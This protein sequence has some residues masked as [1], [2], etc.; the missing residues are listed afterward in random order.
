VGVVHVA[1]GFLVVGRALNS[2]LAMRLS[3][4]PIIGP[5][6]DS[7]R[8]AFNHIYDVSGQD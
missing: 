7:T 8:A 6:V 5:V 4:Y 1:F 3:P 2:Q